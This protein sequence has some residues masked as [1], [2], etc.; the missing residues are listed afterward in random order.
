MAP[1]PTYLAPSR[2]SRASRNLKLAGTR[3]PVNIVNNNAT[4]IDPAAHH[5]IVLA[6]LADIP[7]LATRV[8][9]EADDEK[10]VS[11]T[12]ARRGNLC[13]LLVYGN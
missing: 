7:K 11:A 8:P 5:R 1:G 6:A 10:A 13:G 4:L 12:E 3:H 2:K 9:W